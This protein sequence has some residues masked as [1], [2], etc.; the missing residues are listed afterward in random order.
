MIENALPLL[1]TQTIMTQ[2]GLHV[3]VVLYSRTT[4]CCVQFYSTT[5]VIISVF[6]SI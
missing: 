3:H 1:D 4:K 6:L 2:A 5:E